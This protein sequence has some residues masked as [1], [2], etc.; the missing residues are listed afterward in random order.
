MI[1][2]WAG[3][4]QGSRPRDGASFD[5]KPQVWWGIRRRNGDPETAVR[6]CDEGSRLGRSLALPFFRERFYRQV[7]VFS[8]CRSCARRDSAS[9]GNCL[10]YLQPW[11]L[12]SDPRM[13][14]IRGVGRWKPRVCLRDCD[15]V[16][17][18]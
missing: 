18:A 5:P 2:G 9:G 17:A 1:E 14:V 3:G 7:G 6:C 13:T 4:N 16:L 15:D 10:R 8:R 12:G 11:I